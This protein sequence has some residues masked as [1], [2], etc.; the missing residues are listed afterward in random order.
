MFDETFLED[1]PLS[2]SYI[3]GVFRQRIVQAF[4]ETNV[5]EEMHDILITA[6]LDNGRI[7]DILHNN[8]SVLFEM[9]DDKEVY[10]YVYPYHKDKITYYTHAFVGMGFGEVTTHSHPNRKEA[11]QCVIREAFDVL[12]K[13][14]T[15]KKELTS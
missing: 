10:F 4:E 5:P 12:E 9:F 7:L 13:E 3:R 14:L 6:A 1:H 2:T 8:P 15:I 11:E